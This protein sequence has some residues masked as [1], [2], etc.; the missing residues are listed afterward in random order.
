ME[1]YFE[2]RNKEGFKNGII[3]NIPENVSYDMVKERIEVNENG[4]EIKMVEKNDSNIDIVFDWVTLD[5]EPGI[6][7]ELISLNEILEESINLGIEDNVVY[8]AIAMMKKD[9]SK[10]I[11][12]VMKMSFDNLTK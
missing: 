1:R 8:S 7:E 4:E 3:I 10:S 6:D 12:E 11:S 9:P 5:Y 2:L